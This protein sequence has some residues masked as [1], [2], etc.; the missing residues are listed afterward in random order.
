MAPGI[1]GTSWLRI[2]SICLK[3]QRSVSVQRVALVKPES[4]N[5]VN[6]NLLRYEFIDGPDGSINGILRGLVASLRYNRSQVTIEAYR[7]ALPQLYAVEA[8]LQQLDAEI[9]QPQRSYIQE[10]IDELDQESNDEDSILE[11]LR[12]AT[13]AMMKRIFDRTFNFDELSFMTSKA[14][15]YHWVQFS[16]YADGK[17][18]DANLLVA[19]EVFRSICNRYNYILIDLS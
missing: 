10:I 18:V 11:D 14:D 8:N 5:G 16:G 17:P 3:G 2:T 1:M 9:G 13:T 12:H 7:K 15:H 19:R 4:L 6:M